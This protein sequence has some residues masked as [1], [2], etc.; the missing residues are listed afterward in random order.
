M[1]AAVRKAKKIVQV[2]NQRH[3]GEHW[4]HVPAT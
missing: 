3:S 1:V 2:G 4:K